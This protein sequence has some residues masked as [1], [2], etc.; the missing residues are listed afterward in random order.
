MT[1]ETNDKTM[2]IRQKEMQKEM[3]MTRQDQ[4]Q[5]KHKRELT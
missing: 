2:E 5:T 4:E 3:L 1:R